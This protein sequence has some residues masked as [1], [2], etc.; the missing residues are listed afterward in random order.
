MSMTGGEQKWESMIRKVMKDKRMMMRLMV[1][2]S[3]M[4]MAGKILRVELI[5]KIEMRENI[6]SLQK[7]RRAC[8]TQMTL[9]S[10]MDMI[11]GMTRVSMS[12]VS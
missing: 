11:G 8:W 7:K 9:D 6:S 1:K 12:L 2:S 4:I 5:R 3:A 10:L